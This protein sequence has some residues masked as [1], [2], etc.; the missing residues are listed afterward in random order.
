MAEG[1]GVLLVVGAEQCPPPALL[2]SLD[3]PAVKDLPALQTQPQV[4]LLT[5]SPQGPSLL[6]GGM[7]LT[8]LD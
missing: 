2:T 5:P 1:G 3:T 6:Q 8:I 7:N 4:I